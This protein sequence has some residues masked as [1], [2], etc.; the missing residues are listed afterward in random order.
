MK[1][2]LVKINLSEIDY[3]E[4]HPFSVN[5]DDSLKELVHS[6]KLNGLS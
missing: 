4:G 1:D 3:F 2:N 5:K 6:I